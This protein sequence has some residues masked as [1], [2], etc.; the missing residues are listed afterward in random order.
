MR[1]KYGKHTDGTDRY[2]DILSVIN[3]EEANREIWMEAKEVV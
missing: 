3:P 2:F 1:I